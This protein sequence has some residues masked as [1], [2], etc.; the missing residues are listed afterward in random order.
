VQ[1][2]GDYITVMAFYEKLNLSGNVLLQ[3]DDVGKAKPGTRKLPPSEWAYGLPD[4]K[5]IEGVRECKLHAVTYLWKEHQQT[6]E[7]VPDRDF[8]KLNKMSLGQ[9][10]TSAKAQREYRKHNEAYM[11]QAKGRLAKA[12][13]PFPVQIFGIP[14]LRSDPM[15]LVLNNTYANIAEEEMGSLYSTRLSGQKRGTRGSTSISPNRKPSRELPAPK[16]VFKMR[17]FKQV[18]PRTD[19]NRPRPIVA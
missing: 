7:S 9:R 1:T 6:E 2:A 11:T 16:E 19:T 10:C 3:K 15:K 12:S 18:A 4:K 8:R 14:S 13:A 17:R 5:D